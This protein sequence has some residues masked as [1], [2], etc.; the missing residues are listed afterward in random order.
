PPDRFLG[1]RKIRP[2][3]LRRFFVRDSVL[4]ESLTGLDQMPV[5]YGPQSGLIPVCDVLP[6]PLDDALKGFQEGERGKV[7]SST[8]PMQRATDDHASAVQKAFQNACP[9]SPIPSSFLR[10][11]RSRS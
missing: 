4:G 8:N 3:N 6:V 1:L 9:N 11:G 2:Q 10:K 7:H 5:T